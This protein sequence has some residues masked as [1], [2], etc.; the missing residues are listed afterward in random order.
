MP[1]SWLPLVADFNR[2]GAYILAATALFVALILSTQFSFSTFLHGTG[3]RCVYTYNVANGVTNDVIELFDDPMLETVQGTWKGD[4]ITLDRVKNT[5]KATNS[6]MVI[7]PQT[8]DTNVP[9]LIPN[10]PQP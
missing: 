4:V 10:L 3:G 6:R 2:T 7:R 9:N 1:V 5:I 8:G